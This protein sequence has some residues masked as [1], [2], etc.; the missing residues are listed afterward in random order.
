MSVYCNTCPRGRLSVELWRL[1]HLAFSAGAVGLSVG[2]ALFFS[3]ATEAEERTQL[4]TKRS[5]ECKPVRQQPFVN[6]T[7]TSV[8]CSEAEL[9][10]SAA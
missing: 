9:R 4:H 8:Q 2:G 7:V 5:R 1:A 3:T 6:V 10:L